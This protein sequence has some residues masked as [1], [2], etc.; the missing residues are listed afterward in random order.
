[1]TK[2]D[3]NNRIMVGIDLSVSGT[4]I[5]AKYYGGTDYNYGINDNQ[6]LVASGALSFSDPFNN[7]SSAGDPVLVTTRTKN[8]SRGNTYTFKARLTG[9]YNGGDPRV[10]ASIKIPAK[11]PGKVGG[12]SDSG[13][14]KNSAKLSWNKPSENG[15]PIIEYQVLVRKGNDNWNGDTAL[16]RKVSGRS[17]TVTG[18]DS[19][20]VYS[21]WVRARNSAGWGDWQ[22]QSSGATFRTKVDTPNAPSIG[23]VTRNSDSK[24]TVRWSNN[25]TTQRPYD[26]VKVFVQEYE[27]DGWGPF[28][29]VASLS[30]SSTSYVWTGARSNRVYQFLVKAVNSA[31]SK[32]SNQSDFVYTTPATPSSVVASKNAASDIKLKI[33][34][35]NT[36][37][38]TTGS[39]IKFDIQESTDGGSWWST[40]TT[41]VSS[42]TWTHSNPDPTVTH[43]YRV[44]TKV[45]TGGVG[46][47]TTSDWR[48]SNTVQLLA[49]PNS[50][51]NLAS[52]PGGYADRAL[53]VT[54]TWRHNPVDASDQT[55][56]QIRHRAVGGTWTNTGVVNSGDSEWVLPAGTY[57]TATL[58]E[59]QV[60]TWGLH[61]DPSGY[62]ATGTVSL[63]STPN[64]T[65]ESPADQ[66]VIDR[67][68]L[69]VTWSY[70]DTEDEE[71]TA[72]EATLVDRDTGET[73]DSIAGSGDAS[74]VTFDAVVRDGSNYEVGVRVKDQ[75]GLWSPVATAEISVEYALPPV[76][77]ITETVWDP[78]TATID[79]QF[80]TPDATGAQVEV[81]HYEVWRRI[82][83]ENW[84][85]LEANLPADAVNFLDYFPTV[86][87][88]NLYLLVAVSALPSSVQSTVFLERMNRATDPHARTES[89]DLWRYQDGTGGSSDTE[90]SL[91]S[92]TPDG[93]PGYFRTTVT[94][95]PSGGNSGAYYQ[96]SLGGGSGEIVEASLWV[97]SSTGGVVR[98]TLWLRASG[99]NTDTF[100]GDPVA[101]EVGTWT[102]ITA[103]VLA[104]ES[105]D[106]V[107]IWALEDAPLSGGTV[108]SVTMVKVGDD[109]RYYDGSYPESV[110]EYSSYSW[111]G[112]E[113][114]SATVE[115]YADPLTYVD[116]S[117]DS[118]APALW[119][120][121]RGQASQFARLRHNV[122][123]TAQGSILKT[124]NR[125][126]GRVLP[127]ESRG[128]AEDRVW[129]VSGRLHL[130]WARQVDA[131]DSPDRWGQIDFLPGPHLLR[132][133]S[134]DTYRWVSLS[135]LTVVRNPGGN[136]YDVSF[137]ATEVSAA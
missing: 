20:T 127:V 27:G 114:E 109:P 11:E 58:V 93:N 118:I 104:T 87:G 137:T 134:P 55:K 97:R 64:L 13:F 35:P 24:I 124:I 130:K 73:V 50:P 60:E 6:V 63:S 39:S 15:A 103:S 77:V 34:R 42:E 41:N 83:R 92:G 10:T 43:R 70:S 66:E 108:L 117:E 71:Q 38:G 115:T 62:S 45:S 57:L 44:R 25:P 135:N 65:I 131:E 21:W 67:S 86:S 123:I 18:L 30:K 12:R 81:D 46:N 88:Q 98:P 37:A 106:Q 95:P 105:Y 52:E 2:W 72:W 19:N 100:N 36:L 90:Y 1:M 16:N 110:D 101:L 79:V 116:T 59:W 29:S 128:V 76:P 91:D 9:V 31:G 80:T 51:S 3:T 129:Q 120:N 132:C 48:E 47:G 54:L 33:T 23:N 82:D 74:E 56:F 89:S 99:V 136:V 126:A 49:R 112:T 17:T 61:P 26:S 40:I 94:T 4:K 32:N 78:D 119:L 111:V 121:P 96:E 22:A 14:T 68:T 28:R 69:S 85:V 102:Q 7:V 122:S 5:T 113:D 133:S 75:A 125:F 8:G 53:P 107:R 84:Q